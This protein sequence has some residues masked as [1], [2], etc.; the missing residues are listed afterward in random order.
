M[1]SRPTALDVARLAG[2]S[3]SAVSMVM[4]ER[5]RGNISEAT[6][7]RIRA[8]ANELQYSP[9]SIA[10]SLRSQRTS[11]LGIVSEIVANPFAG[12][13]IKALTSQAMTLGYAT[14]IVETDSSV[15]GDRI[16][17]N[18]LRRRQVDGIVY[19]TGGLVDFEVPGELLQGP[20]VLANCFDSKEQVPAFIPDDEGGAV[21]AANHLLGLGHRRI[22]LLRGHMS[23]P[24]SHR[25]ERGYRKAMDAAGY[26]DAGQLVLEAGW[27]ISD[28]YQA[29]EALLN[30]PTAPTAVVCS[31]DRVATGVLLFAAAAGVEVPRDL[32]VVGF[33]NQ[34]FLAEDL[35][36]ALTTIALPH[37]ELGTL[38]A[39]QLVDALAEARP[40][41]SATTLVDCRLV[42]R[43]ST[44]RPR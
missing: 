19:A 15:E 35:V 20:A 40:E 22:A 10:V 23:D 36:P 33:D 30:A 3:R 26:P 42:I 32:S 31:N 8:A 39:I 11:T 44:M 38:A 6:A 27:T 2:T 34:P 25:R 9:Q 13:L 16:A 12:E 14:L 29:A 43:S 18:E 7:S 1:P 41:K 28:G 5:W 24:A 4:N 37:F 17:I 21:I